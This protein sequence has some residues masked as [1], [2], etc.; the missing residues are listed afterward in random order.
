MRMVGRGC[1]VESGTGVGE[2]VTQREWRRV[3]RG[4]RGGIGEGGVIACGEDTREHVLDSMFTF[5]SSRRT[6]RARWVQC[7][8]GGSRTAIGWVLLR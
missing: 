6:G 1:G 7:R 4:V 2:E 8:K 5:E 3:E